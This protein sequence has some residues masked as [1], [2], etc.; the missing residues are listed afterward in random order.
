MFSYTC[1][2]Y[3]GSSAK[4]GND[5]VD[6]KEDGMRIRFASRIALGMIAVLVAISISLAG[7]GNKQGETYSG[8]VKLSGSTTVLPLA[9]EA[10]N[11]FMERHSSVTVD[12][13]G[14]GSS[15]G[16]TQVKE[17]VVDIGNSSRE[18]K[19]DEN[20]G[21]LVDHKIALDVVVV[22][23]HPDIP[24]DNLSKE[25]V[26]DIFT[27]KITNWKEVGGPDAAIV[28]VVRDKASGTREM[29]DEHALEKKES[30]KN[31]IECNS[32]GLVRETVSSTK[33][34]IG[35][36]SLGYLNKSIKAVKYNG[37]EANLETAKSHT[38]TL[39]RYLHMFT[40]GE[41]S[42][43]VKGFIDYVLS[44]EFQNEVVAKEYIPM[45][46]I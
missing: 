14:G 31:A 44:S 22:V 11:R 16:I 4:F 1:L 20:D 17:G 21:S 25:Q 28:V 43:A 34:S 30:A 2:N 46:S 18:L 15:V 38:Y 12:V 9:L 37:V 45:Q 27:G 39:T 3:P 35:Y 7:C 41:P 19:K 23:V 33:N 36:I 5:L 42:G 32:N 10:A 13:Q 6:E 29:F 8:T 26:K 40:K 24:V